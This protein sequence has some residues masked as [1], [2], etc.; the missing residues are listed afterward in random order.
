MDQIVDVIRTLTQNKLYLRTSA[1][2][3]NACFYDALMTP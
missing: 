1:S 3:L 2:G